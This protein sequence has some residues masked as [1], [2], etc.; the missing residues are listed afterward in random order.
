MPS[1]VT[2]L[3][4]LEL[5]D[6]ALPLSVNQMTLASLNS[7]T[8]TLGSESTLELKIR[9]LEAVI[10][11]SKFLECWGPAGCKIRTLIVFNSEDGTFDPWT[12]G[13]ILKHQSCYYL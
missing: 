2:T 8:G 7:N 9:L 5:P 4:N 10:S 13:L 6:G 11:E 3:N 1:G 12:D